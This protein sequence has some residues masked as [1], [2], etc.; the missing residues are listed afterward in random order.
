MGDPARPESPHA[1]EP[2]LQ[3]YHHRVLEQLRCHLHPRLLDPVG[4][5][6]LRQGP[7][8]ANHWH[9]PRCRASALP[10]RQS[11]RSF[12]QGMTTPG[13]MPAP[14]PR[15]HPTA[16]AHGEARLQQDPAL[17]A[18]HLLAETELQRI[19]EK[20]LAFS[21]ADETEV[22][23]DATCDALTRFA[24]NAIH[25]NVAEQGLTVSVRPVFDGRTARATTNKTDDDSLRRVEELSSAL[26][27]STPRSPDLLPMLGPQS[28]AKVERFFEATA[29]ASPERSEEHTSELQSQSNLVCRLLLE[30]KKKN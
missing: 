10:Q 20:I 13:K 19:A 23:I 3:R 1:Q 29:L 27:R 25:Q 2:Q 26:A 30:K 24:N 7:A 28:Y 18:V 11:R 12:C 17:A 4:D 8:H 5:A 9:W 22:L 14:A 6:Q 16:E 21:E 15:A